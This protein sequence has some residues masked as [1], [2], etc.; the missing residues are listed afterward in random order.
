MTTESFLYSS[1]EDF[2]RES[3]IAG[4]PLVDLVREIQN[5]YRADSRPWVVGFSGG[6][7]STVILSLTYAALLF[8]PKEERVKPVYVVSSDTLVETPVVVDMIKGALASINAQAV[9]D[10]IPI[11]AHAVVPSSDNT[12]WVNLLGKGYPAPTRSFRWCTERM[13]IHPVSEFILDKVAQFGEVIVVL[14]SR[15]QESASRA[16]VIA[17][18]KID[19]SALSRHSSLPNAYTY[20]P[21]E[22]WSSDDVWEYLMSA[23]RAWGGSNRQL[24]ELYKG[25]NAGECPLV[26]DTS[27]P[28]CGNSRFGCWTCTVVTQ[29]KAIEGLIESGDTWMQP[30]L[31]F[32]NL[33]K[34]SSLPENKNTYRNYRR[35]TGKVTYARGDIDDD[36][37]TE[38]KHVPGPYWMKYRQL[39]VRQLLMLERSLRANGHQIELITRSELHAIRQQWLLDPNEPDWRDMLPSIFSEINP[40]EHVEWIRNDSGAFTEPDAALLSELESRYEVS[41]AMIMRLID[42]ELAYAGLA[43]RKGILGDLEAV[44]ARDWESLEDIHQ[45]NRSVPSGNYYLE[46]ADTIKAAVEAL[47]K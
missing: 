17:K 19:G 26:I 6:K 15:K 45:R 41:A 42:T 33:L 27:T 35:R 34:E 30:L 14:G 13:K 3:S 8:L 43:K 4:R 24:F 29:D 46:E 25:S 47:V 10:E 44:L 40:D 28:S 22:S 12:F 31:E 9:L 36:S 2:V 32:R 38:F 37:D 11:T 23:P 18:H 16:Q 7:D 5:I 39:W 21:I 1:H 20:M